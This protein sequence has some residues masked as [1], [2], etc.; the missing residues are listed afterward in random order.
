MAS[1]P[2]N[3]AIQRLL[4]AD[5]GLTA[6]VRDDQAAYIAAWLTVIK[7]DKRAIFSAAAH[8]QKGGGFPARAPAAKSRG[9]LR[10]AL[11]FR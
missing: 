11:I 7:S 5:L 10:T 9:R 8:A 3:C 6:E 1:A 2:L 4:C